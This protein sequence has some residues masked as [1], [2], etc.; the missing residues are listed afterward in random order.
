MRRRS[1][2]AHKPASLTRPHARGGAHEAGLTVYNIHYSVTRGT[3]DYHPY[4]RNVS[5]DLS[6]H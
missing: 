6:F 1:S 5:Y 2:L 3:S 4:V